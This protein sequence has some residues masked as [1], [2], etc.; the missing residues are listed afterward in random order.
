MVLGDRSK[1]A[2]AKR[3]GI[4]RQRLEAMRSVRQRT[5]A[6]EPRRFNHYDDGA[7]SWDCDTIG[8]EGG[9]D[10]DL[11]WEGLGSTAVGPRL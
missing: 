5:A 8:I 3:A 9:D 1:R 6:E 10:C 7:G 4:D 2:A 11:R